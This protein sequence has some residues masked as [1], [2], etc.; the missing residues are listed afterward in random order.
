[1][2]ATQQ[3]GELLVVGSINMDLVF[4]TSQLPSPGETVIGGDFCQIYGGKGANQAVAAARGCQVPVKLFAAVG[5][6][7]YAALIMKSFKLE[8]RLSTE[9]IQRFADAATGVAAIMVD[10][11]G[12]NMICVAAGANELL[13]SDL[14][15]TVA[16]Q[17]FEQA[18]V[19]LLSA[20]IPL[21]TIL[22]VIRR[23]VQHEALVIL[24]PAPALQEFRGNAVLADVDIL[25]PNEHEA[26][27][28]TGIE[29]TG[30]ESAVEAGRCL[31][32]FGVTTVI[33]TLGSQ[34]VVVVPPIDSIESEGPWVVSPP[35][36]QVVD[37]T[38]AGDCFNGLLAAEL[39]R[40]QS[41]SKAVEVAV[42][43]ASISVTRAGAQTSLPTVEELALITSTN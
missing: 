15:A 20:E 2:Q 13:S 21:A 7:G 39:A 16:S 10:D 24:N 3:P 41:L 5:G 31:Q 22:A 30:F 35:E 36:V 38:A 32:E 6:D 9:L 43:G 34:G 28:L 11:Q 26:K 37:T 19:V 4:Q 40:G 25:T 12:E 29:V 17:V 8:I 42:A 1:M 14:L 18:S 27:I 23:S 33:V